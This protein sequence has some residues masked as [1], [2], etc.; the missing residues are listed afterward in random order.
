MF[1]ILSKEVALRKLGLCL[2][3]S[4][5]ARPTVA[6]QRRRRFIWGLESL[7]NRTVPSTFIVNTTLDAVVADRRTSLRE[8]ILPLETAGQPYSLSRRLRARA[9]IRSGSTLGR[10]F[11]VLT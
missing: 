7:E 2:L 4:R 1:R 3:R 6:G 11:T 8:A 10:S 9:V 5:G